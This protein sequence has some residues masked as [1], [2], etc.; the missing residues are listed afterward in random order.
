[1]SKYTINVEYTID[2]PDYEFD[3]NDDPIWKS[4]TTSTTSSTLSRSRHTAAL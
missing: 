2:V 4:T 3:E 1:M